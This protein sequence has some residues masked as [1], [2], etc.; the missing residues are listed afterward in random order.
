MNSD[1]SIPQTALPLF[2]RLVVEAM[3]KIPAWTPSKV[4]EL[5]AGIWFVAGFCAWIAGIRW[6][7][8]ILFVKGALDTL[9]ALIYAM[10][11]KDDIP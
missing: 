10:I 11:E 2:R 8:W 4:E 5:L 7:A 9:C 1:A 3:A 6:A